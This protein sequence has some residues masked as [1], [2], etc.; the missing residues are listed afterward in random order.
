MASQ[1]SLTIIKRTAGLSEPYD[2]HKL[3]ASIQAVCLAA[4]RPAGEAEDTATRVCSDIE[5]WLATKQ[6]ATA[7]DIRVHAYQFL[8]LYS[9]KAAAIYR[10]GH[11]L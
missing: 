2:A 4:K 3:Y 9:P 8:K 7:L 6:E 5:P 11:T 10:H 1:H